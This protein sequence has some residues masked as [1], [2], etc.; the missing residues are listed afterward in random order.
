VTSIEDARARIAKLPE[1]GALRKKAV[2][3]S[4]LGTMLYRQAQM[5]EAAKEFELALT[6]DTT[7]SL[8]RH[9]TLFMGKSYESSGRLDKA[10]SAYE[11][12]L[13]YDPHN[14]RRS[15]DLGGLYEQA[16]LY[17]KARDMYAQAREL[18]PREPSLY[19]VTARVTR[20]MGLYKEAEPFLAQ[21][22]K[23]G[24]DDNA[25]HREKSIIFEHRGR[26]GDALAEWKKGA[27]DSEAPEDIA[28]L[29][30]LSV[31]GN[32]HDGAAAALER[33]KH[34]GASPETVQLY[35]NLV[36]LPPS[37]L[38]TLLSSRG[39]YPE[40]EAL[41]GSFLAER[42]NGTPSP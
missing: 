29:I 36:Q 2:L 27:G 7:R 37:G 28:R 12:A 34:A 11:E 3:H 9:I 17:R 8:R 16:K 5:E 42:S 20:K 35:E 25:I 40:I 24:H 19:F 31:L 32:D 38:E 41:V 14:W 21:A 33:L 13:T 18:N 4:D 1:N 30:Y 15:R 23:L 22:K 10:I 39:K 26:P 6:F